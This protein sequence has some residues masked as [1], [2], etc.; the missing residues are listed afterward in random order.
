[1]LLQTNHN[2]QDIPPLPDINESYAAREQLVNGMSASMSQTD[3]SYT[4]VRVALIFS[5]Y[6]SNLTINT[7]GSRD[8]SY[9]LFI[10]HCLNCLAKQIDDFAFCYLPLS[11]HSLPEF[12]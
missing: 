5:P 12:C 1:M 3:E 11:D 10:S 6:L 9:K 2:Q 4:P 8:E 7:T